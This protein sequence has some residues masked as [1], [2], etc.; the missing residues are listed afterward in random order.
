MSEVREE[1]EDFGLG[2]VGEYAHWMD[3]SGF[4]REEL[5]VCAETARCESA[6]CSSSLIT[7]LL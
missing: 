3:V 4:W 1:G 7:A 2:R 6:Y 5:L